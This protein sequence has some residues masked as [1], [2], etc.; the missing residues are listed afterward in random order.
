M[1]AAFIRLLLVFVVIVFAL[2]CIEKKTDAIVEKIALKNVC[3]SEN[4]ERVATIKGYLWLQDKVSCR[5][6]ECQLALRSERYGGDK[7]DVQIRIGDKPGQME[8]LPNEYSNSD[9]KLYTTTGIA[10]DQDLVEL[11][12][13]IW[14]SDF[15]SS[16]QCRVEV[17]SATSVIAASPQP[18][19]LPYV[20]NGMSGSRESHRFRLFENNMPITKM[21]QVGS[22]HLCH[23]RD[24][25]SYREIKRRDFLR[26]A[27]CLQ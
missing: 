10:K 24:P 21:T 15:L 3:R 6:S 19:K 7:I 5:G 2:A 25:F 20:F 23:P 8:R 14:F 9:L 18:S 17:N 26:R 16:T 11:T 4:D 22:L 27:H 13:K 12:G 1:I